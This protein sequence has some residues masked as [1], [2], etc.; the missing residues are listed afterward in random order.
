M[1][2]NILAAAGLALALISQPFAAQAQSMPERTKPYVIDQVDLMSAA[3]E[4]QMSLTLA[5]LHLRDGYEIVVATLPSRA[6]YGFDGALEDFSAALFE[7][8]EVGASSG[9]DG[10]LVL[11]LWED[12]LMRVDLG[13]AFGSDFDATLDEIVNGVFVP[14]FVDG[15]T[16]GA[17]VEGVSA[18][19][20]RII[21]VHSGAAPAED[22]AGDETLQEDHG[23]MNDANENDTSPVLPEGD[24][25]VTGDNY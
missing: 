7:A 24:R 19:I 12:E 10:I 15:D 20:A 25:R 6:A 13:T 17:L 18:L 22:M 3:A 2:S 23:D 11:I 8:W 21:D 4:S 1:N 9:N 5:S 16:E 14:H